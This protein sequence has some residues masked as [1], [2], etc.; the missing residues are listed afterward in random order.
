MIMKYNMQYM[1]LKI[2]HNYVIRS[3]FF[4]TEIKDEPEEIELESG[5]LEQHE[6]TLTDEK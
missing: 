5:K 4:L 6:M 3:E 1:H 2:M